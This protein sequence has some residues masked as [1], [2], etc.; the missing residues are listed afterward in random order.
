MK[1]GKVLVSKAGGGERGL[2]KQ[3][4]VNKLPETQDILPLK[5]RTFAINSFFSW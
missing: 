1:D 2:E 3:L 4:K 5:E